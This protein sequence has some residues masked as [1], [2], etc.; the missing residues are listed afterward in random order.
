MPRETSVAS[1]SPS[2]AEL[3]ELAEYFERLELSILPTQAKQ[4]KTLSIC[5]GDCMEIAR[6]R[7]TDAVAQMIGELMCQA[8]KMRAALKLAADRLRECAAECGDC[9]YGDGPTGFCADL[10]C[11][12]C[13]EIREALRRAMELI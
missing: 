1:A 2:K 9:N 6:M 12:G 10:P 11:E 13:A 7:G 4:G 3:L 5:D 8:P